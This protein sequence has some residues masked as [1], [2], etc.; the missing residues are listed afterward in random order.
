MKRAHA[1]TCV[2]EQLLYLLVLIGRYGDELGFLEGDVGDQTV[3]RTNTHDVELRLI[4]M[5]R[6]QHDLKS[7]SRLFDLR[8][9][10]LVTCSFLH[11]CLLMTAHKQSH[12]V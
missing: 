3:A 7:H 10:C 12:Q 4:L 1:Q 9:S 8:S 11:T 6:V 5:E 2:H